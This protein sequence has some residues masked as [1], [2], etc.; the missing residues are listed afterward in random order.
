MKLR[1]YEFAK[2]HNILSKEM[3]NLLKKLNFNVSNHMSVITDEMVQKVDKYFHELKHGKTKETSSSTTS[4][5][6]SHISELKQ[7]KTSRIKTKRDQNK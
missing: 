1:V 6:E 4:N 5:H 2:K 3:V 7:K